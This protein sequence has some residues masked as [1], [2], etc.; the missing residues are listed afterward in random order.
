[1][2]QLLEKMDRISQDRKD[3]DPD[4]ARELQKA[5]ELGKNGNI[6]GQ[7]QDARNDLAKNNLNKA[8]RDQK[9]SI[10]KLENFVKE[11]EDRREA[12]LDRLAKKLREAEKALKELEQQQEQLQKKVKEAAAIGDPQKR[13]EELK[14]LSKEQEK[15]QKKTEEMVQQLTRLRAGR[16]SQALGKA[17]S[18]MGQAGQQL[19]QGDD[20][21]DKQDEALDRLNEAR[22]EVKRALGDA[23]EELAREQLGKIADQLK[24]LKERQEGHI[25]EGNRLQKEVQER[26]GWT[27][28]LMFSL[29]DLSTAQKALGEETAKLAKDKLSDTLVFSRIMKKASKAMEQAGDR[30]TERYKRSKDKPEDTKPDEETVKLQQEAVRRLDQLLEAIKQEPG[31]P[32]RAMGPGDEPNGPS[33]NQPGGDIIP[34]LAQLKLLRA[35]QVEINKKTEDFA[36]QHP[37]PKQ[38]TEKDK[39]ELQAIRRDQQ[40]VADLLDELTQ[41]D[42]PEG[43]KP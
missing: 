13:A 2:G 42:E 29:N 37:D 15:L 11:L 5:S 14:R 12:E 35:M 38:L 22:R 24:R 10:K 27:R 41:G 20:A 33:G 31:V 36:R 8:S 34:P 39:A 26:K 25:A 4:T 21:E 9:E 1:M 17:N 18:E 28:P 19:Q 32:Q 43:E 16:A 23:E 3:K 40:E 30:L 6:T 7:M